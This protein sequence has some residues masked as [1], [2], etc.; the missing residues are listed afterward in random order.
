M[1]SPPYPP[2]PRTAA[3]SR[4]A[5]AAPSHHRRPRPAPQLCERRARRLARGAGLSWAGYLGS[6]SHLALA[7]SITAG[8]SCV[9]P[10][11]SASSKDSMCGSDEGRCTPMMALPPLTDTTTLQ[12]FGRAGLVSSGLLPGGVGTLR[13]LCDLLV[14][15]PAHRQPRLPCRPPHRRKRLSSALGASERV[16]SVPF[17]SVMVWA[18]SL[19]PP[20]SRC[21]RRTGA[22]Q[23][24][25]GGSRGR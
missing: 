16:A 22:L 6:S 21:Q 17:S 1:S 25:M 5:A 24:H 4:V 3:T 10:D 8:S 14:G 13:V 7:L 15:V 12:V 23:A 19:P 2:A 20:P 18:S 11:R 9:S